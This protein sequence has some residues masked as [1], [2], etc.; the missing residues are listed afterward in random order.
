MIIGLITRQLRRDLRIGTGEYVENAYN[1]D[2]SP[3]DFDNDGYM[4]Q[5]FESLGAIGPF[6]DCPLSAGYSWKDEVGCKDTDGDGYSDL[7]DSH[8]NDWTQ[9]SDPIPTETALEIIQ[10]ETY[11]MGVL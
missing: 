11:P 9:S 1:P 7:F 2:P 10:V 6:D 5:M 4:D 8:K 3:Y